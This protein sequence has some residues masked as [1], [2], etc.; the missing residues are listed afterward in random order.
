MVRVALAQMNSNAD[1]ARNRALVE[2]YA[3]EAAAQAARL[4]ALPEAA[5]YLGPSAQLPAQAGPLDASHPDFACLTQTARRHNLEILCGGFWELAPDGRVHNTSVLIGKDGALLAAYRKIHLFDATLPDGKRLDESAQ[6]SPGSAVIT[7]RSCLGMLGLS[8]CYD[9]R[10]A[11]LYLALRA[12]GAEILSIPAAFTVPTGAAHWE[13]LVR[14]RAIETQCF[15]LAPAQVGH[16]FG[17]RTSFGHALA[18]DPWGN[19]LLNLGPN[20][21]G[22]GCLDLELDLLTQ[23]RSRMPIAAH[24]RL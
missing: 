7:A 17:E 13:V 20:Q 2:G 1:R 22:I 12:R 10:F 14:A 6:V 8:I 15:V 11:E 16:H 9:L 5:F 18:V 19:V 21:T 4:L 23:V 3:E 24:R